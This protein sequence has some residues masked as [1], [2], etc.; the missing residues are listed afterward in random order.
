MV[1]YMMQQVIIGLD[2]MEMINEMELPEI[3]FG[4]DEIEDEYSDIEDDN[5]EDDDEDEDGDDDSVC[6][7]FLFLSIWSMHVLSHISDDLIDFCLGLG[8]RS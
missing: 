6:F 1:H 8:C 3:D 5:D 7:L 2:T 4:I